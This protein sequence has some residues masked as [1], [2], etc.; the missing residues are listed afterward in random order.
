MC[1]AIGKV[2]VTSQTYMKNAKV[3]R[4]SC[5]FGKWSNV[6]IPRMNAVT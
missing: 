4:Q 2:L 3:L 1:N 5:W 6:F